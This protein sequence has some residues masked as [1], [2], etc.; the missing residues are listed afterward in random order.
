MFRLMCVC[1]RREYAVSRMKAQYLSA[2]IVMTRSCV[3]YETGYEIL[4]KKSFRSIEDH[5]F[6]E[7]VYLY[8][9]TKIFMAAAMY[10]IPMWPVRKILDDKNSL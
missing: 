10:A 6:A 1:F 9:L 5:N 3:F 7:W 4:C 8:D 2:A